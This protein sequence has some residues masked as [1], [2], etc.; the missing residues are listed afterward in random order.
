MPLVTED[1]D[2]EALRCEIDDVDRKILDLVATRMRVV[3]TIGTYKREHGVPIYDPARERKILET[4]AE[5]APPPLTPESAR[6]IFER[7]IDESRSLE[8]GH[9]REGGR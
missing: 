2:L 8:Q 9:A 3:I 5:A 6:R 7:L 4:L 1:L